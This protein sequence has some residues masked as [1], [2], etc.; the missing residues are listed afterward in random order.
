MVTI[1]IAVM[2][3]AA[4]GI[5][6]WPYLNDG[7]GLD[8]AFAKTADPA[9][10]NLVIQR[11]AT[12]AAIKDLEFDH[13]MGKLSD[14]DYGSMRA[15]YETKA[16]GILQELDQFKATQKRAPQPGESDAEIERQVKVLRRGTAAPTRC[17]K[18]G[19]PYGPDDAFCAKCGE[20]LRGVRCRTCGTRG[21]PD[22]RFCARCGAPITG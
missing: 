8:P 15:K 6:A 7:R 21:A 14:A 16:V 2:I 20:S 1:A 11:D 10:E 12:Y 19:T 18:C 5:V 3:V 17:P 4:M 9:L 13:A 22:D